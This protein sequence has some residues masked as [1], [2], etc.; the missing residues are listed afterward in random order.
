[1]AR[2]ITTF[3]FAILV[4]VMC[5]RTWRDPE[6]FLEIAFLTIAWFWLL[7]PTQNPWYWTWALPLVAFARSRVWFFIYGCVLVY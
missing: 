6:R 2:I 7:S 3:A 5:L 4:V 1:M